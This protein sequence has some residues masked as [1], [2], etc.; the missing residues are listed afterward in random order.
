MILFSCYDEAVQ[1]PRLYP[2]KFRMELAD[3]YQLVGRLRRQFPRRE[4][5]LDVCNEVE[6]LVRDAQHVATTHV[7]ARSQQQSAFLGGSGR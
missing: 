6:R 5:V 4:D 3:L 7:V 1:N 2:Q